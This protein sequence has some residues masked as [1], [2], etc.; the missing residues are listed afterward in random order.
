MDNIEISNLSRQFLFN[1]KDILKSKSQTAALKIKSMVNNENINITA[2][3]NKVCKDSE[4]IFNKEFHDKVD[5]YF[6]NQLDDNFYV[7]HNCSQNYINVINNKDYLNNITN[8]HVISLN[9]ISYT[10]S[11]FKTLS[12]I[13][14]KGFTHIFFLQDDVFCMVDKNKIDNLLSFV[15]NYDFNMLNIENININCEKE[16]L[17]DKSNLTV[18]NTDSTDFVKKPLYA[19]DDGPFVANIDFLM[20]VIYDN[21]YFS[22]NDIWNA[23]MYMNEKIV[24]NSIQRLTTN[25]IFFI[26]VNI[27][28]RN[29]IESREQHLEMLNAKF[30]PP[31]ILDI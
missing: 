2:Y 7:F 6:R 26:R 11:L 27:V 14:M 20:S 28:G 10:E 4:D 9:N 16:I 30:R 5:I 22:R 13:K 17:F 15:K 19:M 24:K 18:Y 12:L 31:V 21:I 25:T 1:D 8:K 29:N 3:E 23:E